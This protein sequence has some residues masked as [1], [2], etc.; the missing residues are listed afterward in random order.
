MHEGRA[1]ND[2]ASGVARVMRLGS[3]HDADPDADYWLDK[4][5]RE[6]LRALELCR[7]ACYGRAAVV[8]RLARVLEIADEAS[9]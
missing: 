8:G 5:D 2:Q 4:S 6:R 9:R 7:E 1:A 3:M